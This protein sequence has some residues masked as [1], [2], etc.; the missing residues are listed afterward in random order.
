[1]PRLDSLIPAI[2]PTLMFLPTQIRSATI[3]FCNEPGLEPPCVSDTIGIPNYG[4]H[5]IPDSNAKGDYNSSLLVS[6]P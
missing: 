2:L 5:L 3:T 4:C 6:R 1:M